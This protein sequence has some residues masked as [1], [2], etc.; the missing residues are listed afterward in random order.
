[1]K[2]K[3]NNFAYIDGANLN[4]GVESLSWKLEYRK[5][6]YWLRQKFSVTD[7]RL[8]IG[9]MWINARARQFIHRITK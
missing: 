5:F 6:R 7:A 2:S 4:K 8:F 9:L 3:E 1:M